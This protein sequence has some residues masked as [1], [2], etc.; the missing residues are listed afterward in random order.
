MTHRADNELLD[1]VQAH[2]AACEAERLTWPQAIA[3]AVGFGGLW[4]LALWMLHW[5]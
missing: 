4:A 3:F 1:R 5:A 2:I